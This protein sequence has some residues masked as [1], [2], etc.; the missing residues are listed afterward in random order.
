MSKYVINEKYALRSWRDHPRALAIQNSAHINP[1]TPALFKTLLFCDGTYDFSPD[2]TETDAFRFLT[3]HRAIREAADGERLHEWQKF[4]ICDNNRKSVIDLRITGRCNLNCPHCFNAK[5]NNID[6]DEWSLEEMDRLIAEA[7]D[8]G[9]SAFTFTGG[10][11]FCHPHFMEIIDRVFKNEMYVD[12]IKTNGF[13]I[14]QEILDR[15]KSY[16][17]LPRL[18]ISFDGIGCH[19]KIRG[20]AGLEKRTIDV[21]RLC[22]ENGF[23]VVINAQ[24]NRFTMDSMAATAELFDE[25]G[26]EALRMIRTTEAPRWEQNKKDDCLTQKEYLDFFVDFWAEFGKKP[27]TIEILCWRFGEFKTKH[28]RYHMDACLGEIGDREKGS[29]CCLSMLR[30][31]AVGPEGKVYVCHPS[32]GYYDLAGIDLGNVK[33]DGLRTCINNPRYIEDSGLSSKDVEEHDEKCRNCEHFR[34]C[35][36]GCRMM[37]LLFNMDIRSHD[38]FMCLYYEGGYEEKLREVLPDWKNVCTAGQRPDYTKQE[39][40]NS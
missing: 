14:T 4:R 18:Y 10:E 2:E 33:R 36:G 30:E 26:V 22:V 8:C 17:H 32:S 25:I 27:H 9:V 39:G 21:I 6:R 35:H 13:F 31:I 28:K 7:V 12:S 37:G 29:K 20:V 23:R 5:D 19:D 40:K 34:L 38:P 15:L 11:P 16:G 24:V 3:E 1:L